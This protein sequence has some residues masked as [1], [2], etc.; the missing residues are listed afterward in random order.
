MPTTNSIAFDAAGNIYG[1]STAGGA[2][3]ATVCG[4]AYKLAPG[5]QQT[6]LHEFGT[7]FHYDVNLDGILPMGG[8]AAGKTRL[9]GVT[10]KG[11]GGNDFYT[12]HDHQGSGS[13]FALSA[14]KHTILYSFCLQENCPD[15]AYPAGPLVNDGRGHYYGVATYGGARGA[16]DVFEFTP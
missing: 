9:L 3:M 7:E 5:G 8:L 16:G 15:G 12:N 2:C 1:T 10:V 14:N 4:V 11:G 6:V 13:I